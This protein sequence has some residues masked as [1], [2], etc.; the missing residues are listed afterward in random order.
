MILNLKIIIEHL[1]GKLSILHKKHLIN[2]RYTC[3]KIG[4]H[5][6]IIIGE[7]DARVVFLETGD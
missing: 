5:G 4:A 2:E 1:Y 6:F 7:V 3:G